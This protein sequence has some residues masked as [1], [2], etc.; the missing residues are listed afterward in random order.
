MLLNEGVIFIFSFIQNAAVFRRTNKS[1]C[2]FPIAGYNE[3]NSYYYC[4]VELPLQS[5]E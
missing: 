3:N 1:A 5:Y 2:F 4:L